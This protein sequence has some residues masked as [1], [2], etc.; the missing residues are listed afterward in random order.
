MTLGRPPHPE[1]LWEKVDRRGPVF[2]G[3]GRCWLYTGGLDNKGYG[4]FWF[5]GRNRRA[6]QVSWILTNGPIPDGEGYHGT[7]VLHRC[8]RPLCVR[9]SHL[10]LGTAGENVADMDAKGRRVVGVRQVGEESRLSKLT[11]SDVL[12]IRTVYAG[13]YGQMSELAR[14]FGVTPVNIRSIVRGQSWKHVT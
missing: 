5:E 14:Q 9:P 3:L 1:R 4:Q 13:R 12:M 7:C 2:P 8:D 11:E 6:H 10:F